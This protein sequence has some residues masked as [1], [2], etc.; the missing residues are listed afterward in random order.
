M[1]SRVKSELQHHS[2]FLWGG[3]W[4]KKDLEF[5]RFED[6]FIMVGLRVWMAMAEGGGE[7]GSRE[8]LYVGMYI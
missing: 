2:N 1:N 6:F 5:H 8:K 3:K 7:G 4:G